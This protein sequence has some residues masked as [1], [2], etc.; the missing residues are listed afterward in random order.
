MTI[1]FTYFFLAISVSFLCSFLESILLST[2]HSYIRMLIKEKNPK[3]LILKKFK[4][5]INRPLAAI[6]TLNTV[7]NTVGAAGVGAQALK[8]YGSGAVAVFSGILTL[9]ILILSEI[10]PKTLGA[11]YWRKLAGPSTDII[12]ILIF[13]TYPF[14]VMSEKISIVLQ[15]KDKKLKNVS[16][17]EITAMAEMGEDE[18]TI[19]ESESTIIENLFKLKQSSV[20]EILTPRSVIFSLDKKATVKSVM[21]KHADINFSRIPVYDKNID[22]IIGIVYKDKLLGTIADDLFEK[23]MGELCDPVDTVFEKQTVDNVLN[24]FIKNKSHMFIVKDEFG[25]T[26]GIVT[27]EDCIETLLGV[28]IMDESD[29]VADMRELAKDQQRLKRRGKS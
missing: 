23:T 27:L 7:A 4:N 2:T 14:V 24:K 11:A 13:I 3:G 5:D 29:T 12:R 8:V 22:N 9:G 25:G 18:G 15:P 28:E 16:R 21:E 17:E 6:L 20:E 19:E 26:T 10:I 1:L